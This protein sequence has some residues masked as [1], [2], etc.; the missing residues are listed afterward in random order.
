MEIKL[1]H[2]GNE[3]KV[4][5]PY[6][7]EFVKKCRNLRGEY[8]QNAWCFN[9]N[10]IDYVRKAMLDI[11]GVTGEEQYEECS[12]LVKNFSD[13]ARCDSVTLFGRTIARAFGRDSGAK[14]G[15]EIILVDG[16]ISSGG[17]VKNWYTCV[18]NATFE[19]QNFPLPATEKEEIQKAVAEG[20]CEIKLTLKHEDVEECE[21]F[22]NGGCDETNQPNEV[23]MQ[24]TES[25][26][27]I[28]NE[29]IKKNLEIV[30]LALRKIKTAQS[31][32]VRMDYMLD[33]NLLVKDIYDKID[34]IENYLESSEK[35]L[36]YFEIKLQQALAEGGKLKI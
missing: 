32:F 5:A 16:S 19:I 20:W 15:D 31:D 24:I 34:E 11:Y 12:L 22:S 33:E 36:L 21:K 2:I 28:G 30:K 14:L 29:Q 6:N 7:A 23:Q 1:E 25:P 9:D 27:E 13:S 26:K 35:K 4:I 3:I 8:K 18:D 10:V 17:S